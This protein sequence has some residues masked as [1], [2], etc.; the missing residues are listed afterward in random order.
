MI[1]NINNS[2]SLVLQDSL[3][4]KS[5]TNNKIKNKTKT[6]EKKPEEC[7]KPSSLLDLDNTL[8]SNKIP[9]LL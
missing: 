8:S 2:N 9:T 7:Y 1:I 5:K 3:L 4:T 6:K